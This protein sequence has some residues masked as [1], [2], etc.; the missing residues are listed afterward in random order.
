MSAMELPIMSVLRVETRGKA[1]RVFSDTYISSSRMYHVSTVIARA[2][3]ESVTSLEIEGVAFM[4]KIRCWHQGRRAW[5]LCQSKTESAIPGQYISTAYLSW[6]LHNTIP[7][8]K[9]SSHK[10]I[11]SQIL[12][13]GTRFLYVTERILLFRSFQ[14]I[15]WQSKYIFKALVKKNTA[16]YVP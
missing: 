1:S 2:S 10:I 12:P 13:Q 8:M 14:W 7:K 9:F 15:L 16:Y 4:N 11:A 6:V 3:W 5:L